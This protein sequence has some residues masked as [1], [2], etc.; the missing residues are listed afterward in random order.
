ME[1][2]HLMIKLTTLLAG[3]A[4]AVTLLVAIG[5]A[6]MSSAAPGFDESQARLF[7][8][9]DT[10]P[11]RWLRHSIIACAAETMNLEVRQVV[12]GLRS[13][14]SLKEIG[15]RAGVR[16][17][18]LENGILRC[19]RALLGRMVEAGE[20]Q[21]SEARRIWNYLEDHITRIINFKW[22]PEDPALDSAG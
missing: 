2:N 14:H 3:I 1:A 8:G 11:A 5:P 10:H 20:L 4:A 17:E 16:P 21:S 12:I 13:G 18:R 6:T 15:I 22:N 9:D 7:D 19:E